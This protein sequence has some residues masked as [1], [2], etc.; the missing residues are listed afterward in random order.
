VHETLDCHLFTLHPLRIDGD[1]K[2]TN[3]SL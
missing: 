1:D 2:V 3:V